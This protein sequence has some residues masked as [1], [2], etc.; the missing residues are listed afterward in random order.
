MGYLVTTVSLPG[1]GA[2]NRRR[3]AGQGYARAGARG[4]TG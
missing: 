2:V 3:A 1:Q 4:L